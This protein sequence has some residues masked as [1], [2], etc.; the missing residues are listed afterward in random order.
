MADVVSG[1]ASTLLGNLATKS[2]QE[3]A[4][5]CGLKDDVKNFESS[6]RIIKAYLIDAENKQAKNHSID[7][8]LKQLREAFDDAGDIL[9]EIEYEAK[10]NEVI[11]MYG[12]ICT[13]VRRFFSYTS[14]PLAFRIRMAHKIKDMKQKM[15]EKIREGRK[16]GIVEQ[17]VNAPAMEHNLAWRETASSLPFRLC[18]RL[19]EK[20]EIINSLMTQKSEANSIDVISIIGIG[21]LGK[22]TLAQMVYNDTPIKKHFDLLMWVCVSDDF[23]VKKLIQRII[24]AALKRENVADAN[25]S[26]EY[27]ISLLN[28]TLHGKKF[29]LVLD[30]VWN[31]NHNK[32]DELRNHL[33][34]VGGD[35]GSKILVTTRS[36]KVADI[37]GSNLVMKLEGLPENEC[38][39][40]F[41]KCAFQEEKDEEKYPRLKQIGEQIVKRC[42]GVPLAITTLGCLLRSK[43]HDENEWRKI[44]DS[45]VWN[46]DQEE[47]DILPSLKLSYNHLPPQLK[48][49]FSYCSCFPKD[50]EYVAIELIMLWMAHGLLQPTREEEDA[51]DIGELYI[52]KL[53]STSL[54]QIDEEDSFYFPKIR[55]S[56]AFKNLKM[57][58][59]VHDLAKLTMKES[60]RTR[61]VV[62][63]GQQEA[64]IEWTSDK[65][66]YLRVLHL[67]KDTELSSFPDDCFA[68]M[69]KHLRYLYLGN[70][71]SL[72]KLTDSICKLQSL[73][74]L[75]L[76][77]DSLEEL[78]K[79][80]NKLIYLQYLL[81]ADIK[82]TS[83]SS[84]NIGRFQQL[85]FLYLF[86]CSRLVYVP[87]AVGRLTTL[88]KLVFL[89]CNK[90]VYFED[91][92]EE[93]KQHVLVNNLNL[94]LFSITGSNNLDALPKWLE[95]ATKLQYLS[96]SMS[97]IKSLPT[98]LPMTSLEELDIY[99]CKELSSLPNMDQ[100][101]NLQYLQISY[102]PKLYVRY[103]KET[104]S[105][106]PKIAHIPYC[107][108]FELIMLWMAHGLL[109]PT[110]E[111]EDAED[112][113]KLYIKKLVSTS[114]LQIDE[115]KS[116]FFPKFQ[117]LMTFKTLKMHDLVHDLAKLTMKESSR[118]R[119]VVQE[120]QQEASIEWISDKFNYLRVLHLKEDMELSSFPDDCFATMKK[121]LRFLFLENFPSLKKLPDS[122]CKL[123]SLQSL[124]LYCDSLQE[125]P[126]NMNKLIY[127]QYLLLMKIKITSLS[128]MNIGRFQQL[129][130]L[131][132]FNCSKLVS[133]PSAVGRLTTLKKLGFFWCE[134]LMNFEDEEEEGKQH[135]VVN[136]L[137]LQLFFIIGSKK[138]DFL[139]K[140]LERATKLQYLSIDKTGIKSLPTRL[141]MTSLEE[142]YIYRCEELSS[143]PNMD[144]THN[145]QY[146]VVYN[147]PALYARYNKETGPDWSKIAH[148]PHCKHMS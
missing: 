56:M 135:V 47:T 22:T 117:N 94:Q 15:D 60:S 144:Q 30:D 52:K 64:S 67:T 137:N 104:G 122:I 101:H 43:C 66:N 141:P 113:G 40:L 65:F 41:A 124:G 78:P 148:I 68:R 13:K 121:H 21:G 55:N 128:S 9:D 97:G 84:M 90:L 34:E 48:Q 109:Q 134:E 62:Q 147:C 23:D 71:A 126:K 76:Y 49:C 83:L 8:W 88:K 29:L 93:G 123:Q 59:L 85:K 96:I 140:W 32:W 103:N 80:M 81:L 120:G 6:L 14:N 116:F 4:L 5:A 95:R 87:S 18:G 74:S 127:L 100:T 46:L 82:I 63:E 54:L 77:C 110:R 73:Q 58:D 98:R 79:N 99:W 12:S 105:D 72:K 142:L 16:L 51:E 35:K 146:L 119:T 44:R 24:H 39:R 132:L 130:F 38:W 106:W 7:E 111:D 91:E 31:E 115:E 125:L 27:M 89:F 86:K 92:E 131:Y 1:V 112:I 145:L 45:E 50:Y 61:T 17:H 139:P 143:L 118:T 129:K 107:K 36:R 136:N 28:Q 53:V 19:E 75:R 11:K 69:K 133:V 33:L 42:K 70:C 2:F 26:L 10:L 57:H 37:V 102:C 108:V 20:E 3:I 114:L 138:L 25:S